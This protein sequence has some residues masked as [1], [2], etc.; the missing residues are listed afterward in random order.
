MRKM[1]I[2]L[3]SVVNSLGDFNL[4]LQLSR[5]Y[6]VDYR[7]YHLDQKK[8]FCLGSGRIFLAHSV[9][10]ILYI[11]ARREMSHI[12]VGFCPFPIC[13]VLHTTQITPHFASLPFCLIQKFIRRAGGR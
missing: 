8:S 11:Y 6:G 10:K 4:D 5:L 3:F 7:G 1:C 12:G 9:T 2:F 13:H